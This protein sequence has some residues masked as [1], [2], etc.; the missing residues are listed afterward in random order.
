[1]AVPPWIVFAARPVPVNAPQTTS[2]W[3]LLQRR[4]VDLMKPMTIARTTTTATT[5][6]N[7]PATFPELL[8]SIADLSQQDLYAIHGSPPSA[9]FRQAT[10][11]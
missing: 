5:M 4:I 10:L 6:S 7:G 9:D 1:M 2:T 8:S 11:H 3:L